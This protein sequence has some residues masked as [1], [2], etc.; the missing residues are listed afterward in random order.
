[1]KTAIVFAMLGSVGAKCAIDDNAVDLY[2]LVSGAV[3]SE[4]GVGYTTFDAFSA[5]VLSRTGSLDAY[6]CARC[7]TPYLQTEYEL[8]RAPNAPCPVSG[9]DKSCESRLNVEPVRSFF[10]CLVRAANGE[11]TLPEVPE[12]GCT[13][14]NYQELQTAVREAA[15]NLDVTQYST[16]R[17][18]VVAT[19]ISTDSSVAVKCPGLCVERYLFD[20]YD[21]IK[22]SCP[23]Q[24]ECVAASGLQTL[25]SFS[26]CEMLCQFEFCATGSAPSICNYGDVSAAAPLAA[27]AASLLLVT[28]NL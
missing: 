8:A 23:L 12:K 25:C 5:A 15:D 1:M 28:M 22:E 11:T 17:E 2:T 20:V 10:L 24:D 3:I 7:A 16:S 13:R 4:V 21:A 6:P 26:N 18:F 14:A 9:T 19:L 27:L